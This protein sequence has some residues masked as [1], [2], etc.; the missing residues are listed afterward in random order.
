MDNEVDRTELGIYRGKRIYNGDPEVPAM[1]EHLMAYWR[2]CNE[3]HQ[4]DLD[5]LGGKRG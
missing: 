5:V 4:H 3:Y 1:L 2:K